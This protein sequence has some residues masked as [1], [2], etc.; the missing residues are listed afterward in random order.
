MKLSTRYRVKGLVSEMRGTLKG[1]YAKISSNRRLGAK[2]RLERFAGKLQG[3][4]GKV[5]GVIGL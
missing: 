2:A 4:L 5:H 3:K 1:I